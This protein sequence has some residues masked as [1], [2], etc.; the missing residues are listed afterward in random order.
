MM[1]NKLT[2]VFVK[3]QKHY[4]KTELR[5]LFACDEDKCRKI[6]KRLKEQGIVRPFI[7]DKNR[8]EIPELSEDDYEI[9]DNVTDDETGYIFKFVGVINLF[10]TVIKIFP[11]YISESNED[12][13]SA[14]LK[15]II[16]VLMKYNSKYSEQKLYTESEGIIE[17]NKLPLMIYFLNDYFENGIYTNDISVLEVNGENEII[18]ERTIND[19]FALISNNKPYY[20][21]MITRR[22]K[23]NDFDFF[24]RLHAAIVNECSDELDKS[25]LTELFDFEKAEITDETISEL[26]DSEY[27]LNRIEKEL[28]IQFNTRK[29]ILL[30]AMYTYI[31]NNNACKD[32]EAVRFFGT[33][34][35]HTV[36]EKVCSNVFD[37]QL[38]KKLRDIRVPIKKVA[39]G[40]NPSDTLLGI[41]DKPDWA[42]LDENGNI[43]KMIKAAD[44]LIPDCVFINDDIFVILDAKYYRIRF[45]NG[46]IKGQPGIGDITKQHLYELAY[47]D[48]IEK[49]GFDKEK[50]RNCFLVP[51]EQNEITD[52]SIAEFKPVSVPLKLHPVQVKGIPAKLLF[53]KYLKG[54]KYTITD[55]KLG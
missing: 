21:E 55:L 17:V 30:K 32:E 44:T 33:N 25:G 42:V 53:D 3:E 28:N 49:H 50:V 27:L 34:S 45:E 19:T 26:G 35:F 37:N 54:Q 2:S 10:D 23:I 14:A 36:W 31:A 48:F 5:S 29:Q 11:K 1:N 39:D 12:K 22:R 47:S 9:G 38:S 13:L 51:V 4:S 8:D 24:R 52:I 40:F 41:I 16:K 15:Q 7:P 20:P 43:Q 46:K 6:I 18:W